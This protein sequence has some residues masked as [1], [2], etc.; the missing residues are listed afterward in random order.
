MPTGI[1]VLSERFVGVRE[2]LKIFKIDWLVT[3]HR[4][5]RG[6]LRSMNWMFVQ[7]RGILNV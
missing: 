2:N 1:L 6:N 7:F 4:K 5:A 3:E